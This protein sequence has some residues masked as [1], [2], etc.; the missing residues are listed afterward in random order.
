MITPE[1]IANRI[2][3]YIKSLDVFQRYEIS[4]K[5]GSKIVY[6]EN[7]FGDRKRLIEY[8]NKNPDKSLEVEKDN[9][10]YILTEYEGDMP[11]IENEVFFIQIT[12]STLPLKEF[13]NKD[14]ITDISPKN[15]Y[16]IFPDLTFTL[17]LNSFRSLTW[18]AVRSELQNIDVL[19]KDI[20]AIRGDLISID[21]MRAKIQDTEMTDKEFI[22]LRKNLYGLAYTIHNHITQHEN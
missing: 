12:P 6:G 18:E 20:S 14:F 15:L 11:S 21:K 7:G 19:E 17:H 3:N 1:R 9:V 5:I 2:F 10:K 13:N 16:I 22:E 8:I 4:K